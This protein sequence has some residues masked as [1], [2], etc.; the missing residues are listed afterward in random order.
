MKR[1]LGV[2]ALVAAPLVALVCFAISAAGAGAAGPTGTRVVAP[3]PLLPRGAKQLGAVA[4]TATVS[5]AVVLQPR[6]DAA[7]TRFISQVTDK[8][9]PLFHHYLTPGSFAARFGPTSSTIA[10]VKSQLQSS[11]LTV[12]DVAR[13]GLIVHFSAPASRVET[14]FH[15]GLERYRLANGSIGQARTA[16]IRVPA[17]IAKDVTAVVGLDTTVKL[18]P[19]S[20][21]HAPRS[22]RGSHAAAKTADFIH[23]AA[24]PTPCLAA[25]TAAEQFGG[26]TDDQIAN[27]YGAFGLFGAGDTGAGQ[28]IAVYELEPFSMSDL[29]AFDTCYFGATQ[30]T[31]MLSHVHVINVDG[32]QTAG[33]GSGESI[34]DIQD[35]S[36]FAPGANI[37]VYQAPNNTFGSLDQY[38]KIVNDDVDQIVTTSWGLCEQAVQQGSPGVQQAENEIFQQ[39]AAQGQ[40]V[41]SAAGDEGSND[42]NAFQTT[43]PTSPILSVDDPSSQPYVVAAGGTTM[44]D[45]TQ[46]ALE[47]V[48]NDGAAWGAAGGGI[49]ESWPMPSWQLDSH[50]PG[51]NDPS[52]VTAA[53]N[54]ESTDLGQ[55]YAFCTSDNP[56]GPVEDGCREVP[57]VSANADEFTGGI[58]VYMAVLDGWNTFGGTSSA[59]PMWAAM[60]ADVNASAT[61]QANPATQ[62]GVGFVNPLLYSV[63]SNPTAYAAS[64]SDIKT[65]NNDPYGD[66]NLFQATTG[67]DMASGLGTPQL[68]QPNGGAGLAF[69]LCNQAPAATRPTVTNISPATASTANFGTPGITITG[70]N[71]E[72]NG[73][74]NVKNVQAGGVEFP[75]GAFSVTSPTTIVADFPPAAFVNPSNDPTD[76]AGR[77]AVSVTLNDGETSAVNVN[78]WFTYVDENGSSQ[79]IPAVTSV[80]TYAGPDAGGNTVDIY[81]SGF[82]GATDVTFGGVSVGAGNFTV[83]DDWHI[84][85]TVPAF[86]NGTTTCAQDG[87]SFGTGEDAT[88]DVCQT[89]VVVTNA[90]GSSQTSTIQPLYEGAFNLANDGVIPAP[91]GQEPAPA[92][93][94]YD[95]VPTPTITSISTNTGGPGALASEEGGSVVTINGKGFNLATLEWVNFGDPSQAASQA[96]SFQF[97][98]VTGTKIEILAP[99]LDVPTVDPKTLAVTVKSVAGLSNSASATYAGI[100]T[101]TAVEATSGPTSGTQAG[102]DSGGTP[103]EID[104]TGLANQALAVTFA[105]VITPFS[106]GTQYNFNAASDTKLTTTTVAQNAA[107][108]DT[109]VCTVTDCSEPSSLNNDLS[110]VLFL[111]PPGD[112]KIDSITPS[113]GPANGGTQVT[114]SGHNLGC[115]TNVTFGNVSA[116][117]ASNDEALLDCG[118]TDTVTVTAPAGAVGTVPITLHTVESDSTAGAAAATS[119]FTYTK[120]F[121]LTVHKSGSGSGT[122]T[123]LPSGINCGKTCSHAY[124]FGTVVTLKEKAAKGSTFVGWSGGCTGKATC[125]VVAKAA[126]TVTAKFAAGNCVVPNVKGKSLSA[127][128]STLKAHF[129]SAGKISHAHSST[130]QKG[131]VISQ[132]PNAGTH[133]KHDGKV[134]L[135]VSTG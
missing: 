95:Y 117:D 62:S 53:G 60:L 50:V 35:V 66:S 90:N 88:S 28:H 127:A 56:V 18:R 87:S 31:T 125:K 5:G 47:H 135:T 54:F 80:R 33:P 105:D 6:D 39:A 116:V 131:H 52:A 37:D 115:V 101:V 68:T 1:Y 4:P 64:F 119:Q 102:P 98:S 81:G 75:S 41:F 49:S 97:V 7:L 128:K 26:L 123:G 109:Q 69:Y 2:R 46:P 38:S 36:A 57:D 61:C 29:Q 112:P 99:G 67:Y 126:L 118:T 103:I 44:E 15:T 20:V 82:S 59:A 23:P 42:C 114:I 113:S 16:S 132:S 129:C 84:Q 13:D 92:A 106:F 32:G 121:F 74:P 111:F 9:S 134:S 30:A 72:L 24:S 86:Q 8:H 11:G 25:T 43:A 19:S 14:A 89:Q 48:W 12:T 70:T 96:Q 91:A 45:A 79:T 55:P 10:A 17:T 104:G 22:M 58:T 110:D 34:L 65:G 120:P 94:E 77:E 76:G 51:V 93:T 85:A 21:L 78:S 130:V 133:L 124:P 107:V 83:K 73:V 122:V 71:F 3:K 108:V 100:P 27:A 63:A 40:T